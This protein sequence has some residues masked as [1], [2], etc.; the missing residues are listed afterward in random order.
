[1]WT[2]DRGETIHYHDI[3]K[4]DLV[5]SINTPFDTTAVPATVGQKPQAICQETP[6]PPWYPEYKRLLRKH[7]PEKYVSGGWRPTFITDPLPKEEDQ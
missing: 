3:A 1:M 6:L 2:D 7:Q 4:V 5:H